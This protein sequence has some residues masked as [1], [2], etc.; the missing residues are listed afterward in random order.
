MDAV[1]RE[2]Q[3]ITEANARSRMDLALAE[4]QMRA[5]AFAASPPLIGGKTMAAS[6]FVTD[7]LTAPGTPAPVLT[8]G[9]PM[10]ALIDG[11][12]IA[13]R[14]AA[15]TQ[16]TY[17]KVRNVPTKYYK[18]ALRIALKN[19]KDVE[20]AKK[21][22]TKH[23]TPE[24]LSHSIYNMQKILRST[25]ESIERRYG[26]PVEFEVYLT[27]DSLFRDDIS[28]LYKK[29]R[30]HIERPVNLKGSKEWLESTHGAMTIP[31]YEADDLLS[32]Q[33]TDMGPTNCV[34]VSLDKDLKQ[35][36]GEHYDFSK[37]RFETIDEHEARQ[38][39][40]T[41]A[42][43]GDSTDDIPGIK[44]VGPV[45]AKKI[46]SALGPEDGE[47]EY[48]KVVLQEWV[49]RSPRLPNESDSAFYSRIIKLLSKSAR[50]LWLCR[51]PEVIWNP[52]VSVSSD[53]SS[54]PSEEAKA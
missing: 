27:S 26:R 51:E 36:T 53:S 24:P 5:A 34:I 4:A 42:L 18:D 6:Q 40:W 39:F 12:L 33:A 44:G 47:P 28:P 31:G 32:M 7:I 2:K 41:Q 19:E 45:T 10:I 29:S 13:Y 9:E 25:K 22:I 50:M 38:N 14:S 1:E 11:D 17:Y 48:Y 49:D 37:D 43:V 46:L 35:I 3:R 54:A 15:A 8:S 52:P 20:K 16:G 23:S 21:L 30:E